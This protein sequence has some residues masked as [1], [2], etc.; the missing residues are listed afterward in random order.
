M[1][2]IKRLNIYVT[3]VWGI[4]HTTLESGKSK[5]TT[6]WIVKLL[7]RLSWWLPAR[8]AVCAQRARDVHEELG[9]KRA[10]MSF[11]PMGMIWRISPL[12]QMKLEPHVANGVLSLVSF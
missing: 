8:I 12:C 11:I 2:D 9:Y 10:K 5:K 3:T 4:R 1:L 7:A 6:I